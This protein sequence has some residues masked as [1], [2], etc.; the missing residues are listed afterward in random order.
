MSTTTI[1]TSNTNPPSSSTVNA[2]NTGSSQP[3]QGSRTNKRSDL[4]NLIKEFQSKLGDKWDK[5]HE[6][7]SLFLI[8]KLSR[9]ELVANITPILKNGLIKY[10]NR[11]L[12]LNFSNSYKDIP[13]DIQNEFASFWNKKSKTKT[14]KSSQYERFKQNIMGLPIKERR[15]I[16]NITRDSGK[17]NRVNAGVTLTRHALLPKIPSIQDKEKQQLQVN[18]LVAWQQDVVNGINTPIATD[19]F[20]LPDI[21]NLSKRVI[22]T[23]REHGLTGGINSEVLEIIILGLESYLK[24]VFESAIDVARYREKKY[25]SNDFISTAIQTV[26]ETFG[27]QNGTVTKNDDDDTNDDDNNRDPKRRKIALNIN[28]LYNTFEMF[29]YLIEPGGPKY[30]LSSTMLKDDDVEAE[31]DLIQYL[32]LEDLK[33]KPPV[34]TVGTQPPKVPSSDSSDSKTN[35]ALPSKPQQTERQSHIGTSDELK[36]VLHDLVS[37]M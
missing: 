13:I 1:A 18:N 28:D 23:M 21:D 7:L 17:K 33:P 27:E 19:N 11:L 26:K 8:G 14:V 22:M 32:P 30:R 35:D 31:D 3:S 4:E 12:L 16:R 34:T 37:Q 36:W 9:T 29:P 2:S 10:H 24:N 6:S 25:T 5:Y 20:E 15:R